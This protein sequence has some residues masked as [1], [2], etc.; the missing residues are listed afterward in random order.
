MRH[1]C[2]E[3]W[4]SQ[5]RPLIGANGERT[6][7]DIELVI[8]G[9]HGPASWSALTHT[10]RPLIQ[11]SPV[12]LR[13]TDD[14]LLHRGQRLKVLD[15]GITLPAEEDDS[16]AVVTLGALSEVFTAAPVGV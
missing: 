10:S 16:P 8:T 11:G 9:R 15:A 13:T 7:G 3:Y 1:L 12:L 4:Q 6:F 14:V 2:H 5:S